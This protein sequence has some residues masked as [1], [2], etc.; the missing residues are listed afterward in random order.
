MIK[1]TNS[2]TFLKEGWVA[3]F[4]LIT[5]YAVGSGHEIHLETNQLY[6]FPTKL[7]AICNSFQQITSA[8]IC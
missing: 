1:E 3:R 5:F 2:F 4:L 8:I 7:I 6:I